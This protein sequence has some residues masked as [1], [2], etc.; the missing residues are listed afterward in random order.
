MSR[1][2]CIVFLVLFILGGIA[3]AL[4]K[5]IRKG[6]DELA[7]VSY[8]AALQTNK[9]SWPRLEQLHM[10]DPASFRFTDEA[11]YLNH[12][13]LYYLLHAHLGP[14]IEG[15]PEALIWH[16]LLDVGMAAIGLAAALALTFALGFSRLEFL[17]YAVPL[18]ATPVL[19]PLAGAV[20]NDNAAFAGGALALFAAGRLLTGAGTAW[21]VVALIGLVIAAAAKLTGFLLVG[22]FLGALFLYLVW[23]KQMTRG[24][25]VLFVAAFLVAAAPYLAFLVQYRSLAPET[26]AQLA[27]LQDAAREMGWAGAPR[28]SFPAYAINFTTSFVAGWMPTLAPRNAMHHAMLAI[29]IAAITCAIAGSWL[30]IRRALAG[31]EHPLDVM[32]VAGFFAL[33]ATFILHIVF[34]YERHLA[35]GWL[36]DAYPRYYLPMIAIV[37]LACIVLLRAVEPRWQPALLAFLIGG[38]VVFRLLGG[39]L[40]G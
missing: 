18:I 20:N 19:V 2:L 8:V 26:S 34:S 4:N 9:E 37:P 40:G 13:P 10:L 5:D 17:A 6:F 25:L 15:H 28:L 22:G 1:P 14:A 24:W 7:H 23:R 16:R 3:A 33:A 36:M 39:P 11:S 21:L 32:V 38:P 30:A 31:R 12:T 27:M 35:T 29:P